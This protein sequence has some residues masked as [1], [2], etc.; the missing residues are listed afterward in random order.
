MYGSAGYALIWA[1]CAVL[2]V[3]RGK[4]PFAS[5]TLGSEMVVAAVSCVVQ[6]TVWLLLARA[7]RRGKNW[8][9]VA[10]TAFFGLYTVVALL[11]LIRYTHFAAGF[12]GTVLIA[13]TWLIGGGSVLLLWQRRS[14]VFFKTAGLA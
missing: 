4:N 7:C 8:A 3:D 13:A 14:G 11:A 2:I 10:S 12:I 6:V 1:I 5:L 9:R